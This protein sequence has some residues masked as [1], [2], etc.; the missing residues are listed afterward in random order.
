MGH[1]P[2]NSRPRIEIRSHRI[3]MTVLIIMVRYRCVRSI[4]TNTR[5]KVRKNRM[6]TDT[7]TR[8]D[9]RMLWTP[10]NIIRARNDGLQITTSLG[11]WRRAMD[12][13]R[14]PKAHVLPSGTMGGGT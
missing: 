2:S 8:V 4:D 6:P 1:M 5:I 3:P 10:M 11:D 12:P 13:R 9:V 14:T 7:K